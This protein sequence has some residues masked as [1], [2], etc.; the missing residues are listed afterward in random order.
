MV[1]VS[2]GNGL[3]TRYAHLSQTT[4]NVG[5]RVTRGTQVGNVGMSGSS[6]GPHLHYEVLKAGVP[7]NPRRFID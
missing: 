4:V 1:M 5:D 7:V 3:R 6:T 2:H